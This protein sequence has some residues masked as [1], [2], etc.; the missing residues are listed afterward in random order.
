VDCTCEIKITAE[1]V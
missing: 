1:V